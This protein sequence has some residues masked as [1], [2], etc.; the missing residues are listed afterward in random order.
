MDL[1]N[2]KTMADLKKVHTGAFFTNSNKKGTVLP[3][4][5][6]LDRLAE[7][8]VKALRVAI[9]GYPNVGKSSVL[10]ILTNAKEKV[11]RVSGTTKKTAWIRQGNVRFMDTPGVI[12]RKD[13]KAKM[14][15][16]SSKD[17]YKTENPERIAFKLIEKLRGTKS[18]QVQYK[19]KIKDDDSDYDSD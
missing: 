15:I 14:G 4:K 10:N 11:S 2:K 8:R 16:T 9:L 5:K 6:Y 7:G 1:V 12:P 13:S 17:I 18:L 3:I 19:I